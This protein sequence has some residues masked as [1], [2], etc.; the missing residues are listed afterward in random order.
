MVAWQPGCF[1]L[2]LALEHFFQRPGLATVQVMRRRNNSR[3][4]RLFYMVE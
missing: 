2:R 1:D 4:F 3:C